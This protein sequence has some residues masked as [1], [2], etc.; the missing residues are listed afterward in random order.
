MHLINHPYVLAVVAVDGSLFMNSKN[1][2]T[3]RAHFTTF[4]SKKVN[5][6]FL[7]KLQGIKDITKDVAFLKKWSLP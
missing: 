7:L 2:F 5:D 1:F 6:R 4:Y 3:F